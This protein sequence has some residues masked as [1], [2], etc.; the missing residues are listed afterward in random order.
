MQ[1]GNARMT[2]IADEGGW[3]QGAKPGSLSLEPGLSLTYKEHRG[4]LR[5]RMMTAGFFLFF[6]LCRL[7]TP[8]AMMAT[9]L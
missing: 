9:L 7:N 5:S 4:S 1:A 2:N 3:S 8:C 6:F